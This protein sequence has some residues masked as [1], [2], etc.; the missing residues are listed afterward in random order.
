MARTVGVQFSIGASLQR[1]VASSFGTMASRVKD[2]R[3]DLS[4]LEKQSKRAA[5][6]TTTHGEWLSARSNYRA[7]PTVEART[8]LDQAARAY[9][10]AAK[11]ARA[12]GVDVRTAAT[13]HVQLREQIARTEGAIARQHQFKANQN[14]RSELHGQ[15]LGTVASAMTV[16]VPIKLAIDFESSMADAAKTIDGVRDASGKLTPKY[17]EMETAVK[18]MGRTL[19]LTHTE[20]ARL[21]AAG[22]QQGMSGTAELKEFTTLAAHM[23][24]A[25]GMST[26]AAADAIGGYRT[27]LGLSMPQTREMLDLM[28]YYA[29]TSSA[30]EASIAD[31][32][33]RVGSLGN[34]AG[35]SYKPMTALAATLTSMKVEPERAATGISNLMLA[36]TAGTAATKGQQAAFAT[37]G[38]DTEKLSEKMQKDAPAAIMS[39]LKSIKK[40]P[41]AKQLSIMQQ[42]F[43]KDSLAA[44]A[45][46]L[47]QLDLL[48]GNLVKSMDTTKYLGTTQKEFENRSKTTA[49]AMILAKNRVAELGITIGSVALPAIVSILETVGPYITAMS[50]FAETHQT[51][52]TVVFGAIA[53]LAALK[54]TTLAVRYGVTGVSDAWN[55]GK[56][57]VNFFRRAVSRSGSALDRHGNAASRSAGATQGVVAP[58]RAS[59]GA[60]TAQARSA[61]TAAGALRTVG[62]AWKIALGPIGIVLKGLELL[63]NSFDWVKQGVDAFIEVIAEIPVVGPILK[64]I[65]GAAGFG[66]ETEEEEVEAKARGKEALTKVNNAL[67]TDNGNLGGIYSQG[68]PSV[69]APMQSTGASQN[70]KVPQVRAVSPQTES[71]GRGLSDTWTF[72]AALQSESMAGFDLYASGF[73]TVTSP[74][75]AFVP[76]TTPPAEPVAPSLRPVMPPTTTKTPPLR[77][78]VSAPPEALPRT[79]APPAS[80]RQLRGSQTQQPGIAPAVQLTQTF[81]LNGISDGDFARRVVEAMQ[82]SKGEFER[83]LSSIVDDQRRLA[84]GR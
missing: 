21:F 22:G 25:F 16:A 60:F 38:I 35:V 80:E 34:I 65:A 52:T 6:V 32:V 27:A 12:Y 62:G 59:S 20:L 11:S 30:T 75:V 76:Q 24:V 8:A 5:T 33:K 23:S 13:Q 10:T 14:V 31:V 81:T 49:N 63:Y 36:M 40:L 69:V 4:G 37:L 15:I 7:A 45:P 84:Y 53:A 78:R 51:A 71:K 18:E 47:D 82:S 57:A 83:L 56:G 68:I 2:L 77:T 73:P 42:I 43:G 74:S 48:H 64:A 58:L 72:G 79:S 28:N 67:R 61:R 46:L 44:I 54:V 17:Y 41:K 55:V 70:V 39:V 19:P 1:T 3:S 29:N 9:K 50:Q 26:D 66:A